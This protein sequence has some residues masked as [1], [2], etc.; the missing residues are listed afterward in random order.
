MIKI[1]FKIAL[2]YKFLCNYFKA[3]CLLFNFSMICEESAESIILWG[4]SGGF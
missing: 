4:Y 2:Q 1:Y 3:I